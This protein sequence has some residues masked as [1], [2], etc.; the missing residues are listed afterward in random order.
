MEVRVLAALVQSGAV[1]H[2]A[3]VQLGASVHAVQPQVRRAEDAS[4]AQRRAF[5]LP[6]ASRVMLRPRRYDPQPRRLHLAPQI[7]R[8]H[9]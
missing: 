4:S 6:I 5:A 8:A 9:V 2:A 1:V 3:T 7:G